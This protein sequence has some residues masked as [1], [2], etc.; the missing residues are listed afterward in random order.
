MKLDQR[1]WF[2]YITDYILYFRWPN[3]LSDCL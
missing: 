3:F 1:K 2:Y